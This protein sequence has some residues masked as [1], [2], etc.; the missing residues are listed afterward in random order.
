MEYAEPGKVQEQDAGLGY[1]G[2]RRSSLSNSSKDAGDRNRNCNSVLSN[3][4]AR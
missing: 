4:F 1:R 2:D 3:R